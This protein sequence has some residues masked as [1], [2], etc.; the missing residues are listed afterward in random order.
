[1]DSKTIKNL[2]PIKLSGI[3]TR[4]NNQIESNNQSRKVPDLV[5]QYYKLIEEGG[6]ITLSTA[7]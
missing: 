3:S 6:R 5:A 2:G 4:T 7:I 1:M